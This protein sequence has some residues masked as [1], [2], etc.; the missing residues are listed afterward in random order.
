MYIFL[1]IRIYNSMRGSSKSRPE[2]TNRVESPYKRV[3]KIPETS[4]EK[5]IYKNRDYKH[6]LNKNKTKKRKKERKKEKEKKNKNEYQKRFYIIS[7]NKKQANK[8]NNKKREKQKNCYVAFLRC[9]KFLMTS[10]S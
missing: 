1:L 9:R 10:N 4:L 6:R 8:T 5:K 2:A 3:Q 7:N